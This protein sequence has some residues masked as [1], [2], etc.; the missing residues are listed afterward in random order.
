MSQVAGAS[1]GRSGHKAGTHSRQD[2]LP[3]Q[4]H[5]H[6]SQSLRL[7]HAHTP[8][9]L[10][11]TSLGCG[12]KRESPEETTTDVGGT[13]QPHRQWPRP[14]INVFFLINIIIRKRH[15]LRPRC[16]LNPLLITCL[17]WVIL[18]DRE[19]VE[20]NVEYNKPELRSRKD[21]GFCN[22]SDGFLEIWAL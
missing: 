21:W 20:E 11:C 15:Y 4:G 2:A 1:L 5:S 22:R 3:S 10:T 7:G 17:S 18:K 19:D 9:T 13:C 16:P 8:V 6:T 14:G 12:G